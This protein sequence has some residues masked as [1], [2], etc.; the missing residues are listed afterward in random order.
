MDYYELAT[1]KRHRS[2][3]AFIDYRQTQG[4]PRLVLLTTHA[5][6]THTEFSFRPD[7]ML[8]FGSESSGV[9]PYV[10]E[11]ADASVKIPMQSGARSLNLV[12]AASMIV[13]EALRQTNQFPR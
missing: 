6:H 4:S 1:L 10:R 5:T 8:L 11:T 12:Q 2:W 3:Q 9:P 13:G 7:D